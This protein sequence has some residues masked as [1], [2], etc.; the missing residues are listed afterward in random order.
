MEGY[1]KRPTVK[2]RQALH[3]RFGSD[4]GGRQGACIQ[5]LIWEDERIYERQ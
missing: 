3:D 1:S 5:S 2:K 4:C